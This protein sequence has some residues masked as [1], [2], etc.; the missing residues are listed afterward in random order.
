MTKN[1]ELALKIQ[2]VIV[3]HTNDAIRAIA[4]FFLILSVVEKIWQNNL[5]P[6]DVK[7]FVKESFW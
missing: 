6:E 4:N 5:R 7:L 1:K 3:Y 2:W